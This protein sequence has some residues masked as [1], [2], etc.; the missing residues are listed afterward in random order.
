MNRS[1]GSTIFLILGNLCFCSIG[2]G[3]QGEIVGIL[4]SEQWGICGTKPLVVKGP[5][6][7]REGQPKDYGVQETRGR[8]GKRG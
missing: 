6:Q 8:K 7:Y 1:Q 5:H 3:Y 4:E 2:T